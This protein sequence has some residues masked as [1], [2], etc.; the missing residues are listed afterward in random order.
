MEAWIVAAAKKH[1][2]T[3]LKTSEASITS[4]AYVPE[5]TTALSGRR[6]MLRIA[7]CN[8]SGT[9]LERRVPATGMKRPTQHSTTMKLIRV[10]VIEFS[11]ECDRQVAGTAMLTAAME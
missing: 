2:L 11:E 10:L 4:V 9:Y 3:N 6:K 1:P 8:A 7:P 5:T